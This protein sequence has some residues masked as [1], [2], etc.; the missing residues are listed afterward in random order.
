MNGYKYIIYSITTIYNHINSCMDKQIF[1]LLYKTKQLMN[2]IK[3]K[4]IQ[5]TNIIN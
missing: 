4:D 1:I 5:E 3:I 2:K